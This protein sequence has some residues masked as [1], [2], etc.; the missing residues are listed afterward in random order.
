[1]ITTQFVYGFL[2]GV[3]STFCVLIGVLLVAMSGMHANE[4]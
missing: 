2:A 1:M 4:E 3:A